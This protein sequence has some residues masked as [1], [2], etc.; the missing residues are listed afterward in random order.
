MVRGIAEMCVEIL[1]ALSSGS[2]VSC[3]RGLRGDSCL[4]RIFGLRE[5]ISY[6]SV[7]GLFDELQDEL[8]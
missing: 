3:W 4:H 5:W 8:T 6:T 1:E 7:S 2:G